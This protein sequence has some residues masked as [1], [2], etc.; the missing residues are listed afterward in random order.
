MPYLAQVE[1]LIEE[2][3]G[4][5]GTNFG[6]EGEAL[7]HSPTEDA[8]LDALWISMQLED[9]PE[10]PGLRTRSLKGQRRALLQ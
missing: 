6:D 2:A 1:R 10:G 7:E 3:L 8:P 5:T 9:P 4:E